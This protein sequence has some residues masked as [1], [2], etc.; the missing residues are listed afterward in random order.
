[1]NQPILP[2][3]ENCG[4]REGCSRRTAGGF[5]TRWCTDP[6]NDPMLLAQQPKPWEDEPE[7]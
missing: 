6:A 4:L 7:A 2:D 3:C 1:M 5:C